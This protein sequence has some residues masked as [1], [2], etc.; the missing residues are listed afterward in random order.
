[1]YQII[2]KNDCRYIVDSIKH[3]EKGII[4]EYNNEFVFL[5]SKNIK[6]IEGNYQRSCVK[7]YLK[8]SR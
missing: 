2:T 3:K 4:F 5:E 7:T 1:M 8:N 6:V